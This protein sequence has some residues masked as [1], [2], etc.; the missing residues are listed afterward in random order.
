MQHLRSPLAGVCLFLSGCS[1]GDVTGA[2]ATPPG[3]QPA[4][5]D[6]QP[7]V[8]DQQ[9]P[10]NAEAPLP[11]TQTPP[12]NGS[13]T[14]QEF[15]QIV[16]DLV[17]N[18]VTICR[19]TADVACDGCSTCYDSCRC[20]GGG[21][22]ACRNQCAVPQGAPLAFDWWGELCQ[23]YQ[24][25]AAGQGCENLAVIGTPLPVCPSEL[26]DCWS[27]A[28]STLGC[29]PTPAVFADLDLNQVPACSRIAGVL[30]QAT[31]TTPE[32]AGTGVRTPNNG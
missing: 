6:Q 11:G 10:A 5:N 28:V 27:A 1:G 4:V 3:E 32:D 25:C 31:S 21:N 26:G 23:L 30:E 24:D 16:T 15:L 22:S 9:P 7:P 12:C 29:S 18:Q 13:T 14:P 19:C 20:R 2:S 8:N 17:C